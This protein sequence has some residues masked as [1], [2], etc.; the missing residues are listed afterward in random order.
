MI[1]NTEYQEF[2]LPI[3]AIHYRHDDGL[4]PRYPELFLSHPYLLTNTDAEQLILSE[5]N[6][7]T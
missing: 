4:L 5:H 3:K 6:T 7:Q 1:T 2:Q